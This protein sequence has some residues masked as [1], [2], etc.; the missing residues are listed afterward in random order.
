LLF[1][2]AEYFAF[3]FMSGGGEEYALYGA[4]TVDV[5]FVP[6]LIFLSMLLFRVV[7]QLCSKKKSYYSMLKKVKFNKE[8][9]DELRELMK[10]NEILREIFQIK[11][12][13]NIFMLNLLRYCFFFIGEDG[14]V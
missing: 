2:L 5:L 14:E 7:K 11:Y 4:L 8:N 13:R 6:S 1:N 3:A 10:D 9:K 12:G